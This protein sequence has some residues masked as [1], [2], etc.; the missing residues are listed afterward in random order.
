MSLWHTLNEYWESVTDST[1]VFARE[2]KRVFTDSGVMIIFV[3][4]T[5]AYPIIYKTMYFNERIQD[6]P[7]AVVDL[8]HSS[9]SR[10]FLHQWNASPD[11]RLTHTCQSMAEAENLLRDQKV[12]GIIYFPRDFASQLADPLGQAHI[13][14]YCDMSS[15]LYMKG[16]YL[17]C[18]QV[19]LESMRNIQIDRYEDMGMD[20]EFAWALVQDAPYTDTALFAPTGGYGSFLIPAVLMLILHQTLLFG[21]CM[22]AGTAREEDKIVYRV[23]GRRRSLGVMRLVIGRALAYFAIYYV[24]AAIVVG[25]YPRLFDLPH[26]G[27][28]WD[29]MRFNVPY[30][31]ATIFF[32]M[33]VSL[34]IRNRESGLVLLIST[35]LVFIFMAG[36]SW[37]KEMIPEPWQWV[38]CLLPYTFGVHGYIH[39]NSMGAT[40][41]QV[42]FEYIALWQQA[43]LYFVIYSTVM[44]IADWRSEKKKQAA[45]AISG[46]SL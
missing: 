25:W 21:I 8:S 15:F 41:S 13:S 45:E 12:H 19:M 27:N 5:L 22:L 29:I 46:T 28:I 32:S 11:V 34:F 43:L 1:Y 42:S 3:V 31:L 44:Y 6:I 33:C 37:P 38:A 40:L 36:V 24:L 9:E 17:S 18:N 2:I 10:M 16:I 4:A 35:S 26:I 7:V 23:I 20:K 30:I 39:I 14:L